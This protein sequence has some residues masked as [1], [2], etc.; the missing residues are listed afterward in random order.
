MDNCEAWGGLEDK[1]QAGR[2][3]TEDAGSSA[4]SGGHP[5]VAVL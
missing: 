4:P 1:H 2:I 3:L 5:G